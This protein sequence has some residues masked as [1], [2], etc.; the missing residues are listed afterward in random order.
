MT[1]SVEDIAE[2]I[3]AEASE[4]FNGGNRATN[5]IFRNVDDDD[6]ILT[7]EERIIRE[8]DGDLPPPHNMTTRQRNLNL[9][10]RENVEETSTPVASENMS[11]I[12]SSD[13]KPPDDV[14]KISIKLKFLNDEIKIDNHAHL[15]ETI[16][17]FKRY[18]RQ[19]LNL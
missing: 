6:Q 10:S 16:L 9:S 1:S 8:M 2:N 7:D 5:Q 17:S 12:S 4:S 13:S 3:F 19:A 15:N 11:A 14:E 18:V